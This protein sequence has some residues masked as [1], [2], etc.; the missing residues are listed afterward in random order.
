MGGNITHVIFTASLCILTYFF[1]VSTVLFQF[2]PYKTLLDAKSAFDAW[3]EV[4]GEDRLS[5]AALQFIEENGKPGPRT[6]LFDESK[7][8]G[9]YILM[10]GSPYALMSE[11]PEFGCLAWITNRRGEVVHSWEI[12]MGELWA[13]AIEHAGLHDP[14]YFHPL[15]LHLS[16]NGELLATF[17]SSALFPYGIGI[18]KFDKNGK[19]LWKKANFSHHWFSVA[20]DGLIYTP[21]HRVVDSPLHLGNTRVNLKCDKNKITTDVILV[22]GPDGETREEIPVLDLLVRQDFVGVLWGTVDKCDPMHLNYVEY[23]RA[24]R[25]RPASG[26]EAGDLIISLANPHVIAVIDGQS[27]AL[28]WVMAGRTLKQHS[29]RLLPD[30]SIFVFDNLGGRE[31]EGT[32]GSRIVRL[33]YGQEH[34]ETVFPGPGVVEHLD[35][36]F[37]SSS[38]GH[39]DP[40]P[41]GTRALVS[42]GKRGFVLE[43]DLR[44]WRML[45]GLV[46]THDLSPYARRVGIKKDEVFGRLVANGA[47]YVGRPAFLGN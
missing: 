14:K 10:T 28:K 34:P 3:R 8:D 18:A 22:L 46:N 13:D 16:D 21:A 27:R 5:F 33:T 26:L 11:C 35:F 36:E 37:Y 38:Q 25:A 12:D 39:I 17:H 41:D 4:L 32:G 23:V 30:G 43:F 19:V 20:P 31:E 15:G 9:D 7:D 44:N 47:Y 29:P 40:S 24:D 42:W 2:F 1:G 6:M 45:W